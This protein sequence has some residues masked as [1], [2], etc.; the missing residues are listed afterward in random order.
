VSVATTL[1]RSKGGQFALH[2]K[3]QPGNPY[4]GY[5]LATVIPEM[6]KTIG[7][8]IGRILADA[9]YRGH[10]APQSHKFRGFTAGQKR[11][12]TPAIKR[13]MRGRSA[14]EPVIGHTK[15]E[16]RMGRNCL[17]GEQGDAAT[18][19]SPPQATTSR[20]CST[21]SG[22]FCG[23]SSPSSTADRNRSQ[24]DTPHC[25]RPTDEDSLIRHFTLDPAD[26]LECELRRR[27]Q[28]KLGFA[29]QLCTMRQTGRLLWDNEKPPVAVINYLADQLGTD[30][31]LYGLYAHRVQTRFDLSR[32]LMDY[33]GLRAASK[34]DPRAA[35]VAAI[36]A[37]TNGDS[38]LPIATAIVEEFRKRSALLP[39]L[40]SIEKIGLGGRAIARRRAEKELIAGFPLERLASLDRLLEVDPS[41]GQTRFHWLRSAPEASRASKKR[42]DQRQANNPPDAPDLRADP[43]SNA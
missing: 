20:S 8:E 22:S 18:P 38:G 35:L 30:P 15:A 28:N 26:R 31:R 39:S 19:S 9:G 24:P 10:D 23:C 42:H 12:V 41:I 21:G 16:H 34:Q 25:S 36:E 11:R 3:A 4:D 43:G 1:Q 6:E 33:L 27:P 13:Q 7:N 37:A 40:N 29:V 17:A 2:A 14:I 5:T 32:H